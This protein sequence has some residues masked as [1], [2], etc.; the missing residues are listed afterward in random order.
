MKGKEK[1]RSKRI[2]EGKVHRRKVRSG[3]NQK[4]KKKVK[5]K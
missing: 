4:Q 3:E 1:E 5:R 2:K